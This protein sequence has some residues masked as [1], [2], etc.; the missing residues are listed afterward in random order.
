MTKLHQDSQNPQQQ[1][2]GLVRMLLQV[3]ILMMTI[4]KASEQ[5]GCLI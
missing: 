4:T 3:K 2:T 1:E 5:I